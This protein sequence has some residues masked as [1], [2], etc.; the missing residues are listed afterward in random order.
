VTTIAPR[1]E[2]FT[3]VKKNSSGAVKTS[4]TGASKGGAAFA[5]VRMRSRSKGPWWPPAAFWAA[6]RLAATLKG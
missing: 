2:S 5:P 3:L 1:P 6:I 4:L